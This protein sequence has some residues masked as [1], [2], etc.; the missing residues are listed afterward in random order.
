MFFAIHDIRR[1]LKNFLISLDQVGLQ[2]VTLG[3]A[4]PKETMSSAAWRAKKDGRLA[5][6][7]VPVIDLI[8]L[9]FVQERDHCRLSYEAEIERRKQFFAEM[10]LIE[11]VRQFS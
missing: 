9:I 4:D 5:R 1:R 3:H 11:F 6:F 7:F 8:F 2:L 10:A